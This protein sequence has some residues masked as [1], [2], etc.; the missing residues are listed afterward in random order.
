MKL[1]TDNYNSVVNRNLITPQTTDRDFCLKLNE[2]VRE[3]HT[4][5]NSEEKRLQNNLD[6]E[7]TD[8]MNV[9]S[10]W[11]QHRG[12]DPIEMLKLCLIKNQEREKA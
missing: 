7:I 10:N 6:E 12:K 5:L 11:L 4:A 2:E 8:V 9:C 1:L 3:V